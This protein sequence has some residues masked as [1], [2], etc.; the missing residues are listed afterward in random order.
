MCLEEFKIA[1]DQN[2]VSAL[3]AVASL[4]GALGGL[5]T[6]IAA[7]RLAGTAKACPTQILAVEKHSQVR[8]LS[9]LSNS[10]WEN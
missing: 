8:D 10:V 7:F 9:N 4:I 5:Y 6:A 1:I 2:T 3:T